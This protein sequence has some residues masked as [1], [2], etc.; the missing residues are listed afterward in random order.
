MS[1][2]MHMVQPEHVC[3]RSAP[4]L[5][6]LMCSEAEAITSMCTGYDVAHVW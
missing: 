5:W 4:C 3:R 2:R 1:R 6:A